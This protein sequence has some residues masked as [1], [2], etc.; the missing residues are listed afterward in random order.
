M[1]NK[2]EAILTAII[3]I[4][5]FIIGFI[6]GK[7]NVKE[8]MLEPVV[9]VIEIEKKPYPSIQACIDQGG[10]PIRSIWDNRLKRCESIK[11]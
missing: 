1:N 7:S 8:C 2:F 9:E 3:I 4:L 10:I 11:K 5:F 6:F